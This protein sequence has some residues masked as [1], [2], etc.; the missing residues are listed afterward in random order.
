MRAFHMDS[1][2][3]ISTPNLGK[4]H[5]YFWK[6]ENVRGNQEYLQ[7]YLNFLKNICRSD[8]VSGTGRG[9][10][11][12]H[13]AGRP[14]TGQMSPYVTPVLGARHAH[15]PAAATSQHAAIRGT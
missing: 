6:V 14:V 2:F 10:R 4:Q 9:V 5:I 1:L 13:A 12:S 3:N 15:V 8:I 11:R 7:K